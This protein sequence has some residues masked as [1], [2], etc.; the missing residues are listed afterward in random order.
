MVPLWVLG[1]T[2]PCVCICPFS[3]LSFSGT[4]GGSR[5]LPGL[6]EGF[7]PLSDREGPRMYTKG[8]PFEKS[9]QGRPKVL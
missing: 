3:S 9:H 4:P 2:D 5:V 7:L 8:L 1:P 6:T